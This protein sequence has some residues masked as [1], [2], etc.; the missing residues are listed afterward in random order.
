LFEPNISIVLKLMLLFFV[1][2]IIGATG[3]LGLS[4]YKVAVAPF[5]WIATMVYWSRK[6]KHA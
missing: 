1:G 4:R 3:V 5:L 2:Y 6:N